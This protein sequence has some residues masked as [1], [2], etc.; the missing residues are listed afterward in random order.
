VYRGISN[1][2]FDSYPVNHIGYWPSFCS[3][4]KV[5]DVGVRYSRLQVNHNAWPTTFKIHLSSKN[6]LT[7]NIGLTPDWTY[8][9]LEEEVLLMPGFCF[10]VVK[11]ERKELEKI[12]EIELVEIPHQN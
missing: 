12:V 1:D 4:S 9:P 3:T 6:Q 11:R 5:R 10:I 7:T 2:E 8:F